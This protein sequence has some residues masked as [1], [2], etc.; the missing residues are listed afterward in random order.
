M[1]GLVNKA[2]EEMVC[3]QFGAE[4]WETIKQRAEVDAD[5][6]L[7]MNQYPDELTYRLVGAASETLG[8]SPA[9]ILRAFGRY[10]TLYTVAE[11]YGELMKL[12]GASLREFLG[13]LDNLHARVGLSYPHLQPPSFHCEDT[14]DGTLLLHYYSDREGLAPM[15]IGLLEGLGERFATPMAIEQLSSRE[16]GADHDIFRITFSETYV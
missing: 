7:S 13:N 5:V 11:G 14:T 3:S 12:T 15:V 1:Y 4:T 8:L 16:N 10:W 9:D 2:V 6:F